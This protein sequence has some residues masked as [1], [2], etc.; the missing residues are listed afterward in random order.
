MVAP[1]KYTAERITWIHPWAPNLFS[2]RLTRDRSFRFTPGQF[3]RLGLPKP[4]P[5]NPKNPSGTRIVWRA[6]SILSAS[7]DEQFEFYS[8]VIP[9]GDF[10]SELAR[11]KVGDTVL[12][13]RINYG[14]LSC[15]RFAPGEDLW[16]LATGT[17][18]APFLSILWEPKTWDDYR[19]LIL[20]HSVRYP[21]ELAYQ[22]TIEGFR[23]Q[24]RFRAHAGKLRY[25]PVVTRRRADGALPR[26]IPALIESGEL[27]SHVGLPL[28]KERARVMICGNPDMI[29]ETRRLLAARGLATSRRGIPG[30]L[31][32]ENYW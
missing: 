28:T 30:Q 13:E 7:Y 9:G 14:F 19:R 15:D 22:S 8:I 18:L 1:D 4:D 10:T 26:R 32:V 5:D 29:T 16:L 3:A 2:F 17:G 23:T 21:N 27:E 31:A 24:E 20:V 6:Y 12:V 11:L 25:V